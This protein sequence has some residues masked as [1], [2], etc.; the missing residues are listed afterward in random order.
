V[1]LNVR[2]SPSSVIF[3]IYVY[4]Q[5]FITSE[6]LSISL[7]A[8]AIVFLLLQVLFSYIF[9]EM[10][11]IFTEAVELLNNFILNN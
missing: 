3:I 1:N 2:S 8:G 10:P 5:I 9:T 4:T 11:Y 7:C 6:V